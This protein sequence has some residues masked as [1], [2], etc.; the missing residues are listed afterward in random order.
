MDKHKLL[1]QAYDN[2]CWIRL[3]THGIPGY[4]V[5]P[6]YMF[7]SSIESDND[8]IDYVVFPAKY[9]E[10]YQYEYGDDEPNEFYS[11]C[12]NTVYTGPI[13]DL[14]VTEPPEIIDDDEFYDLLDQAQDIFEE[15]YEA[16]HFEGED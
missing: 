14:H 3:D 4:S 2:D 6:V 7:I 9:L 13:S 10:D 8:R 5:E 16:W 1:E 12:C 15:G 11:L